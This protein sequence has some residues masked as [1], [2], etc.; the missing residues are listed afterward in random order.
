MASTNSITGDSLVSKAMTEAYSEGW[1]RIFG[2]RTLHDEYI[3]MMKILEETNHQS[4][5]PSTD[6]HGIQSGAEK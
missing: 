4:D 6:D 1:D 3:E 5:T 2:K